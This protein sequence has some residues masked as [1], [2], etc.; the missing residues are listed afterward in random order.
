MIIEGEKASQREAKAMKKATKT[1]T[2][3]VKTRASAVLQT[4]RDDVAASRQ[5]MKK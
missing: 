5:T 1:R 3:V 2:T 4:K